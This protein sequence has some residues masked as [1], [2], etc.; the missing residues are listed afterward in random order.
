MANFNKEISG[1]PRVIDFGGGDVLLIRGFVEEYIDGI[2]LYSLDLENHGLQNTIQHDANIPISADWDEQFDSVFSS[3]MME[4]LREP[5]VA[6]D[7]MTRMLS[8]EGMLFVSSVFSWRYHPV[9]KDY[10]RFSDEG[11]KVF[12]FGKKFPYGNI[13]WI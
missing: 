11:F 4:H 2:N 1:R 13:M 12:V 8:P 10:Y 5:G 3:D 6:A 9:P 7:S